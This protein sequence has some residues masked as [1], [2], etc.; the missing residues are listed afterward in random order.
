[1]PALSFVWY[2]TN[3]WWCLLDRSKTYSSTIPLVHSLSQSLWWHQ[4]FSNWWGRMILITGRGFLP[5][6]IRVSWS[7]YAL[8]VPPSHRNAVGYNPLAVL[9]IMYQKEGGY[10]AQLGCGH[11]SETWCWCPRRA[12][13]LLPSRAP[14]TLTRSVLLTSFPHLLIF[15]SVRHSVSFT[16]CRVQVS[17]LGHQWWFWAVRCGEGAH[18]PI[19]VC[20]ILSYG[21]ENDSTTCQLLYQFQ[22]LCLAGCLAATF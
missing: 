14:I 2:T 1:M 21:S 9:V 5:Q 4:H 22:T 10:T 16:E 20:S 18:S 7:Q 3:T 13:P 17:V 8:Q 19:C 12:Q 15:P 6:Q 11:P